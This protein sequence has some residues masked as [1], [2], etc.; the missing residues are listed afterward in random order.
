MHH[1]C[2]K[3]AKIGKRKKKTKGSAGRLEEVGVTF[4]RFTNPIT[5]AFCNRLG[6]SKRGVEGRG[7]KEKGKQGGKKGGPSAWE[8][9][10][11]RTLTLED[12]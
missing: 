11:Q 8:H 2:R 4:F 10:Q 3:L 5:D 9:L 7:L 1:N 12:C 6:K